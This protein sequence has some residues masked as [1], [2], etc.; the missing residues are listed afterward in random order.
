MSIY[1]Q[2]TQQAIYKT[3]MLMQMVIINGTN[4]KWQK[5][6]HNQIVKNVNL[7]IVKMNDYTRLGCI[8]IEILSDS[9]FLNYFSL[10]GTING[11]NHIYCKYLT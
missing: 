11:V 9:D 10:R 4:I 2:L 7:I 1:L 3:I 6:Q 8:A 5:P